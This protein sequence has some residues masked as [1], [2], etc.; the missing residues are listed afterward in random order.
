MSVR[1]IHATRLSGQH[2]GHRPSRRF[3]IGYF[4][5]IDP[6]AARDS[7]PCGVPSAAP[8]RK[9]CDASG[10][11]EPRPRLVY[12]RGSGR[13][14]RKK[15]WPTIAGIIADARENQTKRTV[16]SGHDSSSADDVH[17]TVFAVGRR[18]YALYNSR[19][20]IS[21]RH[22]RRRSVGRAPALRN[23]RAETARYVFFNFFFFF[24]SL[25][26]KDLISDE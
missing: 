11:R 9:P 13:T 7:V 3:L 12:P 21:G 22:R 2:N 1:V 26:F 16:P 15:S 10:R 6:A 19:T 23:Y 14:D 4:D 18:S 20:T 17:L 24:L 8:A 25:C 5:T